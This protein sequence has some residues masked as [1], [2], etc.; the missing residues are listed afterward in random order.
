MARQLL[1]DELQ[2][3]FFWLFSTYCICWRVTLV[4]WASSFPCLLEQ[5]CTL[6]PQN[7][8]SAPDH[9]SSVFEQRWAYNA[10]DAFSCQLP[11]GTDLSACSASEK[12][13]SRRF[14]TVESLHLYIFSVHLSLAFCPDGNGKKILLLPLAF[15]RPS[16]RW[17]SC[18]SVPIICLWSLN[19]WTTCPVT[20]VRLLCATAQPAS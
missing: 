5:P 6:M 16:W 2:E 18:S 3:V 8:L 20:P 14:P 12:P 11:P 19:P 10:V 1:S 7:L 15:R 13:W 4:Q 9:H 17:C